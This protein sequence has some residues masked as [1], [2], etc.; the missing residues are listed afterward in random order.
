MQY[1]KIV[2]FF[3]VAGAILVLTAG[4]AFVWYRFYSADIA[5]PFYRKGNW[6]VIT[7][8]ALLC[9]LFFKTYGAFKFGYSKGFEILWAK[10]LSVIS[11][12]LLT[13]LQI[14]LIGRSFMNYFPFLVLTAADILFAAVWTR[15][16]TA[17]TTALY[18]PRKLLIVYGGD[19]SRKL[20]GKMHERADKFVIAAS[21]GETVGTQTILENLRN[22]DGVVIC[23]INPVLKDEIIRFCYEHAVRVYI[24]PQVS[25]IIMRGAE[26]ITLFDTPL[27]L[28]RGFGISVGI[29]I[30]KRLLDIVGSV[31][32][33][34]VFSV[35]MCIIAAAVK[36]YD[37]GNAI[38]KQT[39]LTVDGREFLLYKFRSMV[40]NAEAGGK[41]VL[42]GESDSRVTPVGAFLRRTR[43]DELPQ[44]WNVLKGD[45]SVV[46]PRPERPELS[47][48]YEK[49]FPEFAYRLKVKAGITGYAQVMGRYDTDPLDK[50][51]L[52]LIYIEDYSLRL[53]LKIILLTL[54]TVLFNR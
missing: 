20:A 22:Y 35:P 2:S 8:Y 25:D 40:Q 41:P 37:K 34:A 26:E 5:L 51:K 48:E 11:V 31:L 12:N 16:M 19:Q 42:S 10:V 33:L 17:I 52:D 53:D 24:S 3:M 44:F 21:I 49:I 38:Y 4:F 7:I 1:K 23:G 47:G 30:I 28:S 29:G 18:P 6:L 13:Y 50:L 39:R 32:A 45:M 46:G 14:S 36:G 9:A 54:R 27:F 15:P 43:L